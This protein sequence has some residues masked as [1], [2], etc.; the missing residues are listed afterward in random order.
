MIKNTLHIIAF[1]LAAVTLLGV[2]IKP[3]MAEVTASYLYNLAEFNGPVESQWARISVDEQQGEVYTLDRSDRIIQIYNQTAMQT[4]GFGEGL[5]LAS[6][7]DLAAGDDGDI[8][9]LY[10]HPAGMVR[11]LD[12]RG[13]ILAEFNITLADGTTFNPDFLDYQNERLL[14]TDSGSMQV[15]SATPQGDVEQIKDLRAILVEK[16][17]KK[18]AEQEPNQAQLKKTREDLQKLAGAAIGGFAA[19]ANGNLYFTVASIFSA[20]RLDATGELE[21]F[22]IAGSA[23]GKFGVVAGIAADS[24]GNIY[25]SDRLRC[26]VLLFNAELSYQS[27]FGYRGGQPQNLVVP[28]DIAV[29]EQHQRLYVAQAAG[30]GVSVFGLKNK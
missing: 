7:T 12:Y 25:V 16:I 15:V 27:E 19:D 23:P 18:S 26:V 6:A 11:Q 30:R 3:A 17:K 21:T 1:I 24:Q 28:D 9:I 13:R 2:A 5:R 20:F 22:G 4:Y 14:L 29:D 10:R 8:F